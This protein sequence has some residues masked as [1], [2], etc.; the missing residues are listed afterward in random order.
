MPKTEH[1][2]W[3]HFELIN[4]PSNSG[5]WARCKRCFKEL[6]GIPSRM[7]KHIASCRIENQPSTSNLKE[8]GTQSEEAITEGKFLVSRL[9]QDKIIEYHYY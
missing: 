1:P 5:N 4:K 7:E 3:V 2:V 6:Q 8:L 9:V